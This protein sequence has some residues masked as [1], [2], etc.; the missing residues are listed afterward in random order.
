MFGGVINN[1]F[2]L[3]FWKFL[4]EVLD[5]MKFSRIFGRECIGNYGE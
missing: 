3:E 4:I 2:I 5:W 1:G